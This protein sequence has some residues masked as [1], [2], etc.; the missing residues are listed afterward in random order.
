MA[1]LAPTIRITPVAT[2]PTASF[3]RTKS[4]LCNTKG[5]NV[6]VKHLDDPESG[7]V[8]TSMQLWRMT[9]TPHGLLPSGR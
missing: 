5:G 1:R 8:G 9:L 3:R 7:D 6:P 4:G 2:F